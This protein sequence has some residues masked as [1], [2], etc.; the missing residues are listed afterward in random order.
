MGQIVQILEDNLPVEN[1]HLRTSS[2][3]SNHYVLGMC[4]NELIDKFNN[5]ARVFEEVLLVGHVPASH[6]QPLNEADF[7]VVQLP[8]PHCNQH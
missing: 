7:V 6:I 8:V 5:Y 2:N 1:I 4:P 3:R